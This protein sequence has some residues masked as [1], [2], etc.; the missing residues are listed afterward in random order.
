MNRR[1]PS[2]ILG[3]L[4]TLLAIGCQSRLESEYAATHGDSV[5]GVRVFLSYLKAQKH[6]V[7]IAGSLSP[8]VYDGGDVL[9]YFD[10]G[11]GISSSAQ[12]WLTRWLWDIPGRDLILVC[13]DADAEVQYWEQVL[14]EY[15]SQYSAEQIQRIQDELNS[16]KVRE[17]YNARREVELTHD[18]WYGQKPL[19]GEARLIEQVSV[20]EEWQQYFPSTDGF[21]IRQCRKLVLPEGAEPLVTAGDDVLVSRQQVG[22]SNVWVVANATLLFNYPLINHQ[23]R[24]LAGALSAS[25]GEERWIVL[26]RNAILGQDVKSDPPTLWGLLT[27]HPINWISAHVF[28]ALLLYILYG[29]AIFG[30][31][32]EIVRR[33]SYRF[34]RHIQAMGK[35]LQ[36]TGD[37]AFAQQKIAAYKRHKQSTV[38]DTSKPQ[39]KV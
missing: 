12:T 18:G 26:V 9:I 21:Q 32:R 5:N 38:D 17:R 35:L 7:S 4:F 11:A 30:R 19:E 27:I 24:R 15:A 25:L 28:V 20:H 23:N 1:C 8:S 2:S 3:L 14:N 33:E 37:V 31:P 34:A 13:R 10:R 36:A 29:L 22:E 6:S 16:A 39:E